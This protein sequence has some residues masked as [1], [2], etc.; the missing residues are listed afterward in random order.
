MSFA[1]R[2]YGLLC[3]SNEPISGFWSDPENVRP[4]DVTFSLGHEPPAWV[5]E[6]Q[7]LLA[8]TLRTGFADVENPACTLTS[9]GNGE[10]FELAYSDGVRFVTDRE[11]KR[12]WG[13]FPVPLTMDDLGVYLRGPLMGF[14]L[15]RRGV[16][17]LHASAANFEGRAVVFCGPSEAGKS[18]I[19]AALALRGVPVIADDITALLE[20]GGRFQVEPGYPRICLWPKAVEDLFG[21]ADAL[22]RLTQGWE[23]CFLP[24][25][26]KSA[27]F[28]QER[29]PLGAIYLLGTRADDATSP[30]IEPLTS[31]EAVLSLL[32]NTYMNWLLDRG[33][34]VV[35]FDALTKI[36]ANVPVRKV[37]PHI[38]PRHLDGLYDLLSR[39]LE[40]LSSP[41]TSLTG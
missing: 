22:P 26:G 29:R 20:V 19:A 36:L 8:S 37:I 41:M 15:R 23:K 7:S 35:E 18:T 21:T 14:V 13:A 38:D 16:T 28:E 1:Y 30:R 33:Q 9:F 11:A 12:V 5:Q 40:S 34:R 39:D 2:A 10:F 27:R 17:A 3:F 25:D 31:Q 32:R 6:A 24:L 4:P